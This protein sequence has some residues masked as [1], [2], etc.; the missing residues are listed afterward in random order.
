MSQ[1]KI[2]IGKRIFTLCL[3]VVLALSSSYPVAAKEKISKISLSGKSAVIM[4]MDS[5]EILFSK[6]ANTKRHNASTTKLATAI[7]AVEKNKSLK[8]K[9]KISGNA[10][11]NG[12]SADTVK[13]GMRT[14]DSYYLKDLLHAMLIKSANDTAVAIAE[15]T[16]GSTSR[17]MKQVNKKVK[18]I[19]CKNTVFGTPNGLR[20]SN[21]HYTTAKD[22]ALIMRYAYQNEEI[23]SILKKKSYSF[24][25]IGGR[26]HSVTNTNVL[27]NSKDY[28]CVGK[29]GNGW[30][31]KYC[32]TGV[33][34]YK[35]HSYVIVTL[36]CGSDGSK[37]SDARKLMAACKK[38]AKEVSKNLALNQKTAEIAVGATVDLKVS[39]SKADVEWSSKDENIAT[40]DENGVVTGIQEGETTICAKVYGKTLKCKVRVLRK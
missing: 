26:K 31:A 16:S 20:S 17:F 1:K 38:N 19:G 8:K 34:T 23:R 12:S 10:S 33:Y 5:G 29:T 11:G 35:D 7:V 18:E 3:I 39:R 32:F 24:K 21:T 22:L 30:T 13:L 36:G 14:G 28:Y 27:L 2:Y 15:G 9:I 40:V 6:N 4:D 25:S 37:W